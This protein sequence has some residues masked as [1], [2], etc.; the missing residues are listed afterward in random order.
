MKKLYLYI[1]LLLLAV[2]NG[3]AQ[4]LVLS[5]D[6]ISGV[7]H[8]EESVKIT[9]TNVI[10]NEAGA[11]YHAGKIIHLKSGFSAKNGSVFRAY[12]ENDQEGESDASK[13]SEQQVVEQ[14]ESVVDPFIIYPNPNNGNF[15][16]GLN[17]LQEG[18]IQIVDILGLTVYQS[19][20][21]NQSEIKIDI[22]DTKKG[23]YAVKVNA[24]NQVYTRKIIKK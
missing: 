17:D 23:I 20:F 2:G 5:K 10:N 16:I 21:K 8:K 9:A 1:A 3:F 24:K 4:E 7:N 19:D 15:T 13:T 11:V 6:I 14:S 18:T 22:Q 12:V